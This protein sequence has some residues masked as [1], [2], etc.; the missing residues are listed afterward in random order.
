MCASGAGNL[1]G[2]DLGSD[3]CDGGEARWVLRT[4]GV[5]RRIMLSTTSHD[6]ANISTAVEKKDNAHPLCG[7][8]SLHISA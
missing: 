4:C 6:V 1:K 3:R 2:A 7:S 5:E 8:V